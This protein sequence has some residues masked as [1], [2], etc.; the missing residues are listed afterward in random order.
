M[1]AFQTDVVPYWIYWCIVNSASDEHKK[2]SSWT[3]VNMTIDDA[4]GQINLNEGEAQT[5][6]E[7]SPMF[8]EAKPTLR[9]VMRHFG[10]LAYRWVKFSIA[11]RKPIIPHNAIKAGLMDVTY[12]P[13]CI[14]FVTVDQL[15]PQEQNVRNQ[16]INARVSDTPRALFKHAQRAGAGEE[17]TNLRRDDDANYGRTR[18]GGAMFGTR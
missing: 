1:Q 10:A 15:S 17:D 14:D 3:K 12:F 9:A 4:T 13:C 18:V 2:L 11:K 16:V 5:I 8:D 7:M 6:Y